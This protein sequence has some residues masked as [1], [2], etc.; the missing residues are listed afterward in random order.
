VKKIRKYSCHV[1][2]FTFRVY[3]CFTRIP[4]SVETPAMNHGNGERLL[5]N[6]VAM[7]IVLLQIVN[8]DCDPRC[9]EQSYLRGIT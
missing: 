9:T 2:R 1:C 7:M 6:T 5:R 3:D 4:R 8:Y